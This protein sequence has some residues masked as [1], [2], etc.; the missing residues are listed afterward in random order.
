MGLSV[1]TYALC[2]KYTDET[3]IQ[4]GGL[5]GAPCKVKSVVKTDGRSVVTLEWK[6]DEGDTRTSEVYV[7]D[8]V[9]TWIGGRDYAVNDVVVYDDKLFICKIA[10]S[11]ATF[12]DNKWAIISSG[13]SGGDFHVIDTLAQRPS[14]LTAADRQMYYCIADSNYYVWDGTQWSIANAGIKIRELT[15]EQYEALTDAEKMDGTIYFVTDEAGGGGGSAELS[16]DMTVVK[17]V[18]GISV[19]TTYEAGTSL[20]EIIRAMLSPV[21]YPTLTNPSATLSVPGTTLLEYGT[22]I[23]KTFTCA[24]SQ[25][26]IN[27]AY[28]TNGKRSGP[29]ETY[30]LN[31]GTPQSGNTFTEE[32][33]EL[34]RTFKVNVTYAEGPQPKD[35]AGNNYSSPLPA[36]N[37]NSNTI[38][39]DFTYAL[40]SNA[41]DNTSIVKMDLVKQSAGQRVINFGACDEAHPEVFDIPTNWGLTAIKVKNDLTGNWD[42]CTE[43]FTSSSVTHK[44]AAD[45]DVNYTRY[46][47]NLGYDMGPREIRVEWS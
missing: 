15:Q 21:L 42:I 39:Y 44:D 4:F 37:V 17:A 11:D 22:V 16:A 14:D 31:G 1:V 35:S 7:N 3:A 34:N 8:G 40:W 20:E 5:K 18:G 6:N 9:S 26:S 30:S 33:S 25:G 45:N 28:G 13:A 36:G 38:T 2:K 46:T 29:A 24:F 23:N 10:N 19:G 47:C 43:D 41:A 27:P 12:N 32:V